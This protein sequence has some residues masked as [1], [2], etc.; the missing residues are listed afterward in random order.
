MKIL[1]SGGGTLGSVTPLLAII[2]NIKENH[3]QDEIFWVTTKD[4]LENQF[5]SEDV[6]VYS[7]SSAK[8]RRYF[9]FRNFI[10][11]FSFVK[12]LFQ[13][14][15]IIKKISPDVI[16]S[17]GAYVSVPLIIIGR[18]MKKK[19][20][21]HQQDIKVGLANRIMSFFADKITISFKESMTRFKNRNI[22]LTGNP[23]RFI[24]EQVDKLDRKF[25]LNKYRLKQDKPIILVLGGSS[26]SY[27]LNTVIYKS[28]KRLC[29]RFQILHVTGV[30][31]NKKIRLK[32]YHQ[33]E[34]LA[35]EMLD[36]MFLANII[37]SRA[38]LA[39]LTELSFLGKCSIVVPLKG[40]QEINSGYF[41]E[42]KAIEL[43]NS[44]NLIEIIFKLSKNKDKRNLLKENIS[45]IMLKNG[46]ENI[47]K[48]IYEFK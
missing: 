14:Y 10:D 1:F 46:I 19:I 37:V 41:Y 20:L 11:I 31:K 45:K 13:S 48:R 17:A 22:Y 38:G 6:K 35:K 43:C 36:L 44:D 26:G 24:Q 42:K 23:C 32:D 4:G 25:L 18:L 47:I 3:P 21:I 27:E 29:S 40:H 2:D 7:I 12:A 34:F 15:V 8:L 30:D 9:S 28:V 16:I 39:T 33:F 5:L